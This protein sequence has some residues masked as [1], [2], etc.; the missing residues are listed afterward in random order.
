MLRPEPMAAF[1]QGKTA[2]TVVMDGPV[3]FKDAYGQTYSPTNIDNKFHGPVTLRRALACSYNVPAVKL[4]EMIGIDRAVAM[5]RRLGV[6]TLTK[7]YYGLSVTLGSEELP[8]L[9]HAFGY[10]VF[11]NGG[12]AMGQPVPETERRPGFRELEPAAILR[13]ED[14][15][16]NVIREYHP[17]ARPV[18]DPRHVY[19]LSS[20]LSD[21]EARRPAFGASAQ[22]LV[23]PDRPVATKTGSTN[24]NSDAWCMG[25]TPQYVVGTWVGNADRRKMTDLLGSTGAGPIYHAIMAA[26]HE[27][28]AVAEFT[29]PE[30]IVEA[31]ICPWSGLLVGDQCPQT[32]T[33]VFVE[34]TAPT[35]RCTLTSH[36]AWVDGMGD[37]AAA[38][39]ATPASPLPEGERY[40]ISISSPGVGATLS[41]TVAITGVAD[42]ADLWYH[43]VEY[44]R[45]GGTWITTELNY[46]KTY[47][48]AG[49]TLA[50][51]DT[52]QVENGAYFLRAVVVEASGNYAE[53]APVPVTVAN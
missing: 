39:A 48:V 8:L 33:E 41:G 31:G 28:Q 12:R 53:T 52:T 32:V 20:V 35:E 18:V 16:G 51:W 14:F 40:I 42:A 27:G 1:E 11:A 9:D 25:Y 2:A 36:V 46:E 19:V 22:Y 7:D 50:T 23:L 24:E 47:Y 17:E 26:L 43:K 49:G 44:S 10:S 21:P 37:W 29:R 6:T 3:T 38:P 13:I 30:G 5:A 4:L 15:R 45:D 34:G